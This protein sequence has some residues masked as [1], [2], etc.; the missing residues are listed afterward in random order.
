MRRLMAI[1][2]VCLLLLSCR[3]DKQDSGGV[4]SG[5]AT[6][7][8]S[9]DACEQYPA[10]SVPVDTTC[11]YVPPNGSMNFEVEWAITA[12]S[13]YPKHV[14]SYASPMVGQLTDDNADGAINDLD[15]P[16]IAAV[17]D[18][19][20]DWKGVLRVISGDGSG[21]HF[22]IHD[23]K[24]NGVT[25]WPYRYAIPALGDADGDGQPDIALTV[26]DDTA[27]YLA[28][29]DRTGT[30]QWVYTAEA[31]ECRSHAPALVDMEGDGAVEVTMGHLVL[32]GGNGVLK[33]RGDGGRGYHEAYFNSGFISVPIDL[34]G[35]GVQELVAGSHVYAPDGTTQCETG[36]PDGYPAVA[37]IDGDGKGEFVV[38]GNEWV[39]IFDSS[40]NLVAA[41][42]TEGTGYGGPATIAD[43]DGD[44][45]P[46]LT[47]ADKTRFSLYEMDGS[48]VWTLPINETSSGATAS[49]VFDFDGDGDA[50]VVYGDEQ[51]LWVLD[52]RTGEI[53][54]EDTSHTSGTVHEYP[55]IVDVDGDGNAEIVVTNS[56]TTSGLYVVG[57]K[58]DNWVG[59]RLLWNQ[60]AYNIVNIDPLLRVPTQPVSNWPTYNNFRQGAPGAL[61][62]QG[63]PD[64]II[65]GER[66]CQSD[67]GEGITVVMQVANQGLERIGGG[68]RLELY[69]ESIEGDRTLIES[70]TITEVLLS[71]RAA[72][73]L[74]W[75][76]TLEEAVVYSKLVGV[77][78]AVTTTN[79]CDDTNNEVELDLAGL[80]E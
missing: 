77:V 70:E 3:T 34:D 23:Q 78:R 17:F 54:L 59:A 22:S 79:E 76:Y 64:L 51:A 45:S 50:E 27:C 67:C 28:L 39:R 30:L 48:L 1:A 38:T 14:K 18:S 41:W 8:T 42:L 29:A 12:F 13:E 32:R 11:S 80:C 4:D 47:V 69:G 35:D 7:D 60:H 25:Y 5:A 71:G 75:E 9:L 20:E 55:L 49:S 26:Y 61:G 56:D 44:G 31:L 24:W 63:S 37:D 74:L 6:D 52:G 10:G 73:G 21:P 19:R 36:F 57:E 68:V 16:D 46:E 65:V 15:T 72:P 40:C 66:V 43:F 33:G 58:D 62:P 53:I 2:S